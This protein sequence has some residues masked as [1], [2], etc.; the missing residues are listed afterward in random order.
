MLASH[1]VVLEEFG[2]D[3]Q[4]VPISALKVQVYAL[5]LLIALCQISHCDLMEVSCDLMEVSCDLMEVSCDLM[6]VS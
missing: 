6:E 1:G 5:L 4:A 2:G 3:V